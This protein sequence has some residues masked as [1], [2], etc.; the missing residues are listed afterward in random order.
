[1]R[2]I[3]IACAF[4]LSLLAGCGDDGSSSDSPEP[5]PA[6]TSAAAETENEAE[7]PEKDRPQPKPGT[8]IVVG[9]SEYGEMLYDLKD[10]A[11]YIFENDGADESACYDECA[12]AWPPVVTDGEPVA[13]DGTDDSLLGTT[14]RDDGTTQVTYDGQ[15]LYFYAHEGPGEVR[16][17]NVDLNGG[18]WWV[19]G[20]DGERLA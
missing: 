14:E 4:A 18:F 20:P 11:I 9:D 3:V 17:H 19:V 15:P 8:E 1:M 13:G 12:E 5:E 6:T 16:C 2:S 10:Q 7:K